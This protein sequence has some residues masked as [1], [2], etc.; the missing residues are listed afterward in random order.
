MSSFR[1]EI[2]LLV[3]GETNNEET[4]PTESE[5]FNRL[6]ITVTNWWEGNPNWPYG[7]PSKEMKGVE[8]TSISL[9]Q[10]N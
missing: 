1:V 5:L 6:K 4:V 8:V 9:K 3:E 2:T 7:V 10:R